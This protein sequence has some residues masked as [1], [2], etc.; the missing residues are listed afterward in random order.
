MNTTTNGSKPGPISTHELISAPI[1]PAPIFAAT[2]S[3]LP[4]VVEH[5]KSS[6]TPEKD[7]TLTTSSMDE[8]SSRES[9]SAEEVKD[10]NDYPEGGFRAWLVV[11]GSFTGMMA[12]FGIMNT[13]KYAFQ[14][15][16][17][18]GD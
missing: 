7:G 6:S 16:A 13:G 3:A 10:E 15:D 11:F 8:E 1:A 12:C 2:S 5:H 4:G 18:H 9:V 14:C 17:S